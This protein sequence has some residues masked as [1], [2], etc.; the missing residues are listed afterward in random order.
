MF[1][2]LFYLIFSDKGLDRKDDLRGKMKK[3]S[4][5]YSRFSGGKGRK[6]S[7][8][9]RR[10]ALRFWE[11]QGKKGHSWLLR[12]TP[13]VFLQNINTL[14]CSLAFEWSLKMRGTNLSTQHIIPAVLWIIM[15]FIFDSKVLFFLPSSRKLW[16]ANLLARK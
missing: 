10:N 5:R 13:T 4:Y 9:W 12:T 15:Y 6:K 7:S 8:P 14:C 11:I 3:W 16:Q 2:S 1:L